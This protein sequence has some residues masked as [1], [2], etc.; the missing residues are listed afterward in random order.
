MQGNLAGLNHGGDNFHG[1]HYDRR[2]LLVNLH[3]AKEK[4][5][6][7]REKTRTK[8]DWRNLF[9]SHICKPSSFY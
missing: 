6:K 8:L 2:K 5:E 3:L 1:F 9:F 7:K 4:K